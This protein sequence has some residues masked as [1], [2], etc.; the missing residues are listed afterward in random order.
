[1]RYKMI[2]NLSEQLYSFGLCAPRCYYIPFAA[3]QKEDRRE[4][5]ACYISLNGQWAFQ[6]YERLEDIGGDFCIK[7]LPNRIS[8]PSCVQYYGYDKFQYVNVRYPI[9]FNPPY[10]PVRNPAYHYSRSFEIEKAEEL[11]LV[12]EGVDSCFYVYI[13]GKYVGFSQI[14]H[15]MSEFNITEYVHLGENRLDVVVQ[16]WCT[17]TYFEDQDKWRFTGIFRDVY[18]LKRPRGHIFDYKIQ[19]KIVNDGAEVLFTYLTG[20]STAEVT[21]C[22]K[23]EKV[24]AGKQITFFIKEAKLWSAEQ[25]Y[26]YDLQITCAGETIFEKVGV[27]SVEVKEGR[28]LLNDRP[29]KLYGVNRHDFHPEKGAA[30]SYE[31]LENDVRLMK[32]LNVN[33]VRTSHYPAAPEFY[34]LCDK[35]GLYVISESDLETH[36]VIALGDAQKGMD[37]CRQFALLS[38]DVRFQD[39][40][41]ERQ[42]ANVETNKNHA[43]VVI[44]SIGNESGYGCNI[45]AASAE[46]KKRDNRPVHY[47]GVSFMERPARDDE[48][49]SSIVDIQSRM[50]PSVEWMRDEFL[51]DSR[52]WRP[53]FLCEYGHA[54]GNSPGGL[55]EYWDLMESDDRFMGGCIWEWADH[56][57][58]FKNKPFRY[59]GD[60]NER[61]HDRNFCIDGI[62]TADRKEKSGAREMKFVY[63]PIAFSRTNS[64]ILLFNKNYFASIIGQLVLIYK[65]EG[66]ELERETEEIMISPRSSIE[67]KCKSA[68]TILAYVYVNK[69]ECA[70]GSFFEENHTLLLNV[71]PA[72]IRKEHGVVRAQV[73]DFSC[74]FDSV[75]GEIREL[76]WK[77]HLFGRI[78]LTI[79]RAP[80]D[81]DKDVE[82][83]LYK[84]ENEARSIEVEN[85]A[86]VVK[87]HFLYE[88]C[89]PIFSYIL[90]YTFGK[91]SVNVQTEWTCA[92]YGCYIPRFGLSMKFARQFSL[93]RYCAYGPGESYADK[94]MG[95]YKDVFESEVEKEYDHGYVVPQESGSHYKADFVELSDGAVVLRAEG[96]QSF[97]AIPYS[98]Q[99]LTEAMHDD[100]LPVSEYTYLTVDYAMSGIGSYSCGPK[101][102]VKYRVPSHGKGTIT[103]RLTKR[104]LYEKT[105]NS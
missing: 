97:C 5:S 45:A 82:R 73:N 37:K 41:V 75:T 17:G 51:S 39:T 83:I 56:G 86:I 70:F 18:L 43:C 66:K 36:G 101:L 20:G 64:G 2:K 33:A 46:I 15:K 6:A 102:P 10:V 35:Y 38:D 81:N 98:A 31:D 87:G 48:Y 23:T 4:K 89:K 30:V 65:R 67:V 94:H 1:M 42:I 21:I 60:F 50:Y 12:F 13:N 99:M 11:Y 103:L 14:S 95:T 29:I 52:E 62:V 93:L 55:K 105:A 85:E 84:V 27:R 88:S 79:W 96:M 104:D 59:G 49:Y 74:E 34:T 26:L 77:G 40:Y 63:Q 32:S 76:I 19:T 61:T 68:Q 16:K 91:D 72:K 7:K 69:K 71:L 47:E 58:K 90:R 80:T 8:V 78:G 100:E 53:L 92:S 9:P 25:P 28:F 54:M 3:D 24:S 22:G 57:V 44:W